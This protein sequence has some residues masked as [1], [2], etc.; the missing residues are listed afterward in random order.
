MALTNTQTFISDLINEGSD[1]QSNLYYLKFTGDGIDNATNTSLKVRAGDFTP[2]AFN[3]TT[4]PKK[5]MTIK[6]DLPKPEISGEKKISFTFRVDEN[7]QV[8]ETLVR[9]KSKIYRANLGYVNP[10]LTASN[11]SNLFTVDTYAYMG[12]TLGIGDP[13]VAFKKLY[14]FKGCWIQNLNGLTFG[15]DSSTPLTVRA[16]VCFLEYEDPENLLFT[17]T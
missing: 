5:Y 8:Y 1:A 15:Y 14:S 9:L 13:D 3:Q 7:Y 10:N 16:D 17:R 12:N 11:R 6:V 4:D 2:P